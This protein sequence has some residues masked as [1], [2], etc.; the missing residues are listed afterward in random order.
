[1]R[2]WSALVALLLLVIGLAPVAH[3]QQQPNWVGAWATSQIVPVDNNAAPVEDLTD[4]TLRQVV[5]VT[6]AGKQLRV[7]LSNAFGNAPLAIGAAS[8]ARSAGNATSR[9]DPATLKP[10]T[11]GGHTQA[12]IPA[13]ADYWS[14]PVALPVGAGTDLAITLFLPKAPDRQTG[15][16]GSRATSYFVHGNQV[17]TVELPGAKTAPRWF[18]IGG[19]EV[20]APGASALVVL[21]DSI[22]DGYGV[23]PDTNLR[24]PDALFRRM[25]A[26]PA[27]RN[28]AVL[29]AGIGG[30]RLLLDGTGPN[31]LARFER[32]VLSVPG[33]SHMI[34]L[35][36]VNDLGVLTRDA[37]AT[38]EQHHALAEAMI[39]GLRQIVARAR[40]HGIKAIGGTI[41][42][43]GGSNYYH[44]DAANEADRAAVNNW[45]RTPGNFDAVIDFD[46]VM[47][48]PANPRRL[49]ADLDSGDGLHP[50]MAGYQ[51]LADAVPLSLLSPR[52]KDKGRGTPPPPPAIAITFD[53]LP[54]HAALPP[55]ETR[56]GVVER[57]LAALKAAHA[58]ATG[59]INGVKLESEPES[60]AVL[61]RW[62]AAGLPLGNHGW[63][64]A[65]LNDLT[66]AQFAEELARNE[67]ILRDKMGTADWHWF[68]YPFLSE[69]KDTE[70]RARVRRLL[71]AKG[72]KVASVTMDFGDWAYNDTYARCMAK[73]DTAAVAEMEKAWL[74]GAAANAD[75]SRAMSQA[76]HGRDIP[77]VLLMHLGAFDARMLPQLLDLYR[78]K[79]FRLV[80]LEEAERDPYYRAE[81]N[82]AL[83]PAPLGLEGA[84][85]ARGMPV[86]A[87]PERLPLDTM[88]R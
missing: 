29:N 35:V 63:R 41:T 59:F 31:A 71:A 49:R 30:N 58:P 88:C 21:G 65:N 50:A 76:L 23:Q 12:L 51:V 79:G 3:A 85:A 64:H 82:P 77:Y 17:T 43:Y 70:R 15:H 61:D 69:G 5:R 26:D 86:P 7:R 44:P 33:V 81:V 8:V 27:T 39:D 74:A 67:P 37:P 80:S 75:R 73:G 48:D 87:S 19:V 52:S 10:L 6:L 57:I 47:R 38:P 28:M 4:A 16:P 46:A 13:G 14:D 55:G 66:D 42:P 1:M 11:F 68:R 62:R 18:V 60:A 84:L 72:Y 2:K 36:G 45:I 32:D 54:S 83:P 56:V 20:D 34:V 40:A 22:T 78:R 9:I 53:D 24:W 25:Q